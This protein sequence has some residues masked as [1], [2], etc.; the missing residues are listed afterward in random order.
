MV[1]EQGLLAEEQGGF[2]KIEEGFQRPRVVIGAVRK[3]E[4]AEIMIAF[5]DFSKAYDNADSEKLWKCVETLGVNGKF[6]G[7]VQSLYR[8]TSCRVRVGVKLSRTFDVSAG[9][10]QGC[11]LYTYLHCCSLYTSMVLWLNLRNHLVE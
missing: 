6:L 5:I 7:F 10:C 11:V 4:F 2:R 3:D 1:K 8:G 9:L